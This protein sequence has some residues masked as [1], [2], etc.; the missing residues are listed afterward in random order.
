M[1]MESRFPLW[2]VECR[3]SNEID[4]LMYI[5]IKIVLLHSTEVL[6]LTFFHH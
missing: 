4:V 5:Y 1:L 6:V 2:N 3:N